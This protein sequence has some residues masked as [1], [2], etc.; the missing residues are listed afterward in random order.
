M[1]GSFSV[2]PALAG[3]QVGSYTVTSNLPMNYWVVN[4]PGNF[5]LLRYLNRFCIFSNV[6]IRG[7]RKYSL[8]NGTF[9]Q[10]IETFIDFNLFKISLPSKSTKIIS[11]WSFVF[12]GRN[13]QQNYKFNCLG[14][15][16]INRLSGKKPKVRGVARNPVDHP[17]GGRTKTNQPEVS[18]WGWVAKRN[19]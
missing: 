3:M 18:I 6:F 7:V 17:H 10:L 8:S 14:K 11:G 16:G 5:V 1:T 9:S 19:K 15:A 12:L 4:T 13:L 2:K